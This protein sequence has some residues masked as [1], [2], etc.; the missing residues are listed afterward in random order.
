MAYVEQLGDG[1]QVSVEVALCSFRHALTAPGDQDRLG[2]ARVG[3][4]DFGEGELNAAVG[5]LVNEVEEL[6]LCR[7]VSLWSVG[8]SSELAYLR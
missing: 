1:G 5:E 6:T 8:C 7:R 4:L 3:V 2:Q